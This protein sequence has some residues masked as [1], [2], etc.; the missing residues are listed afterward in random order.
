MKFTDILKV[1]K[2]AA[3]IAASL[4]PGGAA[5]VELINAILPD[6]ER[7]P[8]TATGEQVAEKFE[9]LPPDIQSD[10]LEQE[11]KLEIALDEGRT[12]RY[13][14][15]CESDHSG[16]S[17][18]PKIALRMSTVLCFEILAFTVWCFVYPKQMVNPVIWTVFGTLTGVPASVLMKYFGDLKREHKQRS[19]VSIG[20]ASQAT[21]LIGKLFK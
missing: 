17:T 2:P 9:S 7:L 16:H 13:K 10:M 20:V 8:P 4:I 18:R 21:N 15:M 11:I 6:G 12:D 14:A 19:N 1:L 3:S 5:A